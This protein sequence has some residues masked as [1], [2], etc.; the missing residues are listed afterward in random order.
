MSLRRQQDLSLKEREGFHLLLTFLV[1]NAAMLAFASA[2][3]TLSFSFTILRFLA[4][5]QKY[6]AAANYER[7]GG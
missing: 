7:E 1:P 5:T 3:G 6:N 2:C 4:E